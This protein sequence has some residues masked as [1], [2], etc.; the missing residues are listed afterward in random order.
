MQVA[1]M[2]PPLQKNLL[3]C[4]AVDTIISGEGESTFSELVKRLDKKETLSNI[5]G[6]FYRENGKIK[7]SAR[8]KAY[9]RS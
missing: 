8:K 4:K 7:K 9:Y 3:N 5:P 1:P 6:T 2:Q